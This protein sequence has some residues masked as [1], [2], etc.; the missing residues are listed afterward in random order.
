[1]GRPRARDADGRE[2]VA[3]KRLAGS[4]STLTTSLEFAAPE[5]AGPADLQLHLVS[6]SV[7]GIDASVPLLLEVAADP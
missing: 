3:L 5:R 1:M 7:C 2:L 6:D 4:A